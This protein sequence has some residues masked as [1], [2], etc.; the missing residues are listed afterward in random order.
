MTRA[1]VLALVA[2][3]GCVVRQPAATSCTAPSA[4]GVDVAAAVERRRE[5]AHEA[6][7]ASEW[8]VLRREIL[9]E[10]RD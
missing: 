7:V 1:A 8:R 3:C 9:R 10:L 6:R 5:Q 4:G 2:L